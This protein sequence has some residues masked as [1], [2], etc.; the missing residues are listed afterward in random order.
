MRG[1]RGRNPGR[2][3]LR[4]AAG[5]HRPAGADRE[6]AGLQRGHPGHHDQRDTGAR[7]Q[8]AA[9][10]GHH[11]GDIT[12]HH[13]ALHRRGQG[14]VQHQGGRDAARLGV[15]QRRVGQGDREGQ[16]QGDDRLAGGGHHRGPEPSRP[17]A[18]EGEGRPAARRRRRPERGP[19][20]H[21]RHHRQDPGQRPRRRPHRRPEHRRDRHHRRQGQRRRGRRRTAQGAGGTQGRRHR[22]PG[23]ARRVLR[24]H[25][26]APR[27]PPAHPRRDPRRRPG[28]AVRTGRGQEDPDLL[29]ASLRCCWAP[30]PG[31]RGPRGCPRS[32]RRAAPAGSAWSAGR[33][34]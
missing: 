10:H 22:L 17:V 8:R 18:A 1:G 13:R 4:A 12:R 15:P 3:R 27:R 9:A 23:A 21:P 32:G 34:R 6:R 14:L 20:V 30:P 33:P 25:R 2:G 7:H 16:P 26:P 19:A 24:R 31:E 29:T 11:P 5:V 28:G